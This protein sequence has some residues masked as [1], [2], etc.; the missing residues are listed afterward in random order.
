[1]DKKRMTEHIKINLPLTEQD[2]ESGNGEGVWMLVDLETKKAYDQDFIGK[3][4]IGI[5]DNDSCYYPGLNVGE[6]LPFE[7]RG[8]YRP[9]VDFHGFLVQLPRLTP[10][11]KAVL[12][13][14]IAD[15][16]SSTSECEI[17]LTEKQWAMT[18]GT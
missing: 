1:M 14:R 6:L 7:M 13:Q 12:I 5:L 10:E 4:Y 18:G 15:S 8:E 2:Y 3:R 9:V 17:I 11:G 16:R